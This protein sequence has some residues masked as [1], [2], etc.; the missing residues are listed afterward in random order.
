MAGGESR[1]M[2]RDKA[3]LEVG[4]ETW[5]ERQLKELA[6]FFNEAIVSVAHGGPSPA[7]EAAI[8]RA[9]APWQ[10]LRV[11]ADE[12]AAEGPLHALALTLGELRSESA[13]VVSVDARAIDRRLI[14]SLAG[15]LVE[16]ASFG[17]V[18]VWRSAPQMTHA[19]WSRSVVPI[20]RQ[21]L[22]R[23]ERRL[24]SL[25]AAADLATLAVEDAEGERLFTP[26][27]TPEQFEE[28]RREIGSG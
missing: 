16:G 1:R 13:F 2:R 15:L 26:I 25:L 4:G 7:L 14:E 21:L 6:D 23:G 22:L 17:A 9:A 11:V 19:V 18:P 24:R 28:F 8:D 12:A 27:N 5:I 20:A 3:L 10:S